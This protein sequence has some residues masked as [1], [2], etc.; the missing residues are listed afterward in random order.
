MIVLKKQLIAH[1][2]AIASAQKY[3]DSTDAENP[4]VTVCVSTG[5]I[6][7]AECLA[8]IR[9]HGCVPKKYKNGSTTEQRMPLSRWQLLM[10]SAIP[11]TCPQG[12]QAPASPGIELPPTEKDEVPAP[13]ADTYEEI[14][15]LT[16]K[17]GNPDLYGE[18]ELEQLRLWSGRITG[19]TRMGTPHTSLAS[20]LAAIAW[21]HFPDTRSLRRV[22][23]PACGAGVL[24]PFFPHN[25]IQAYE[26]DPVLAQ[27]ARVLHPG[28]HIRECSFF[29]HFYPRG[30]FEP[31]LVSGQFDLVIGIP[32]S[33]RHNRPEWKKARTM[34]EAYICAGM[35]VLRPGG[36]LVMVVPYGF[37]ASGSTEMKKEIASMAASVNMHRLPAHCLPG[38]GY[39][40]D[41]MEIQKK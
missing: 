20:R 33:G 41:I 6:F 17:G 37:A 9:Q 22:L 25:G 21:Q 13:K 26:S 8:W 2:A 30:T 3:R 12:E 27:V 19:S 29:R 35:H 15:R 11:I 24:A 4:D 18:A 39:P 31:G 34:E 7:S 16:M 23:M 32:E 40:V 36:W 14:R 38:A 28:I 10:D 1:G 5:S